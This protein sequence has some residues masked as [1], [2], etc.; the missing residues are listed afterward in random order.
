MKDGIEVQDGFLTKEAARELLDKAVAADPRE[1]SRL[2]SVD[3]ATASKLASLFGNAAC[4]TDEHGQPMVPAKVSRGS[5]PPHVD[6]LVNEVR[7]RA[8]PSASTALVLYARGQ[9]L[10]PLSTLTLLLLDSQRGAPEA[11]GRTAAV[12]LTGG[13]TLAF[14]EKS[15]DQI[16]VVAEPGRLVT[17]DSKLVHS[18]FASDESQVRNYNCR[19][20]L[21]SF[22][23]DEPSAP[24]CYTFI[25]VMI[26]GSLLVLV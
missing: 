21:L 16:L 14:G 26:M 4:A 20:C 15:P 8:V 18:F 22:H 24:F 25:L 2:I 10:T 23:G 11:R 1:G 12:Y 19:T 13:G 17:W 3:A 7:R 6:R 9:R 5:V